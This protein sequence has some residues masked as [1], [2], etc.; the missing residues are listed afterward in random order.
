MGS[1]RDLKSQPVRRQRD[2]RTYLEELDKTYCLLYR[3][4]RHPL[5]GGDVVETR[6]Y[7]HLM[8]MR[9]RN[10]VNTFLDTSHASE[11]IDAA[12]NVLEVLADWKS[13]GCLS[14]SLYKEGQDI[15]DRL[16]ELVKE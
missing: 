4:H 15:I 1:L 13:A 3:Y 2:V 14:K 11:L 9:L 7:G 8:L 10:L 16:D 6:R 12:Q 5:P